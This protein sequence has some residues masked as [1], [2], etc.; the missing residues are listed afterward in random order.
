M[1]TNLNIP[2]NSIKKKLKNFQDVIF[3]ISRDSIATIKE[4]K[5]NITFLILFVLTPFA[6]EL[7]GFFIDTKKYD[8]YLSTTQRYF[9]LSDYLTVYAQTA[10]GVFHNPE[11]FFSIISAYFYT[12]GFIILSATAFVMLLITVM[13]KKVY[14]RREP[15]V[16]IAIV[17]IMFVIGIAG[18]FLFPTAPPVRVVKDLFYRIS[19]LPFGDSLIAIK[20]NSIPSGHIYALTVPYIVAKAENY[21]NWEYLFGGGLVITSWVVLLTGDHYAIDIFSAY[22]LCI[23]L[24]TIFTTLYDYFNSNTIKVPKNI[25]VRRL[26]SLLIT[27]GALV[28]ISVITFEY[29]NHLLLP[30][31]IF[32]VVI[33]WPIIVFTTN[34]DGIL[35]GN[36]KI[37]RSLWTDLT[38]QYKAI[39]NIFKNLSSESK[40]NV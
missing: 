27:I 12:F 13:R 33:I 25:I 23:I 35:N 10:L 39:K 38:E 21:R 4:N 15:F 16:Y 3:S 9:V 5:A 6:Y 31:Q 8:Q 7:L 1:E 34:T 14:R 11:S 30:V 19:V 20:Y 18:Y 28:L 26:R 40:T 22:I 32:C 24:F 29:I 17:L 2:S 36:E 37:V